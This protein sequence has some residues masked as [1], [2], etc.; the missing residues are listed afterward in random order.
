MRVLF[1]RTLFFI[2]MFLAGVS[3]IN[4]S[5]KNPFLPYGKGLKIQIGD[6]DVEIDGKGHMVGH[7][8][9]VKREWKVE[10]I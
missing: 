10:K 7:G 9:N 2:G 5:F 1:A 8:T 3:V 4:D 6:V